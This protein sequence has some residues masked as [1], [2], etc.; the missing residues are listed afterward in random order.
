MS[1]LTDELIQY[2]NDCISGEIISCKKNNWA[3]KRFLRDLER[4]GT[5]D[6]PYIFDEAKA[7]KF[8]E[9]M[10]LFKHS[11]GPLEGTFKIPHITES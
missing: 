11:K 8:L 7:N 2:C 4:Q 3:C 10:Q 9:W 6:F 1:N 5:E